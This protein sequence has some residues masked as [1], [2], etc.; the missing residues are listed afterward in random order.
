MTKAKKPKRKT[1]KTAVDAE[2][3][4]KDIKRIRTAKGRRPYFFDDPN[5]DRLIAMLMA[6]V[7]EVSVIR[8]RLDTHERLAQENRVATPDAIENYE[9]TDDILQ[10]RADWRERY[11]GRILRIQTDELERV[12]RQE[13]DENIE[14]IIREVSRP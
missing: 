11:I 7:A 10:E 1:A 5:I 12:A 9:P 2:K 6:L 14:D 13:S 3:K 4:P 8:E